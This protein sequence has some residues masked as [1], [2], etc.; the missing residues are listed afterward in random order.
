METML[1]ERIIADAYAHRWV[2]IHM[3]IRRYSL[4]KEVRA[5]TYRLVS[6][7]ECT[8]CGLPF[9]TVHRLMP[10]DGSYFRI[11]SFTAQGEITWCWNTFPSRIIEVVI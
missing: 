4:N 6:A 11:L 10:P 7:S 9:I 3:A 8:L 2:R 5:Y 1:V